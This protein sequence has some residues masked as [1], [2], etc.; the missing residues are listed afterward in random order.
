MDYVCEPKEAA[1][2]RISEMT[3]DDGTTVDASK[4]YKVAG[5]STVNSKAPGPPIWDVV[6]EYLKD[7][8]TAGIDRLN[9]PVLKGVGENPGLSD[10]DGTN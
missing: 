7:R 3:L 8:K 1:G 6:A 4:T 10:Y 9:T 5:W 2:R